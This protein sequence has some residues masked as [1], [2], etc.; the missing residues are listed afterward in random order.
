[1]Q[2][3]PQLPVCGKLLCAETA[4]QKGI[5]FQLFSQCKIIGTELFYL[6]PE[7]RGVIQMLQMTQLMD[8]YICTQTGRQHREPPIQLDDAR[9]ITTAPPRFEIPQKNFL[10]TNARNAGELRRLFLQG[11]TEP[12]DKTGTHRLY[13]FK[14]ER[15]VLFFIAPRTKKYGEKLPRT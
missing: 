15:T 11:R 3:F 8:H 4:G 6:A 1:M 9:R 7:S 12:A 2:I 13:V 10:R 5:S 14:K